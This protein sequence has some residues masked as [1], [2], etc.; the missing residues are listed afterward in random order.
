MDELAHVTHFRFG[1][2]ASQEDS[3]RIRVTS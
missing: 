2:A 1:C 3:R